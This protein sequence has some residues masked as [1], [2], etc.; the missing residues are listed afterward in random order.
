MKGKN[1]FFR[2]FLLVFLFVFFSV[3]FSGIFA[4]SYQEVELGGTIRIG[5]FIYEDDYTPSTAD[6]TITVFIQV[7]L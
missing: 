1:N 7:E 3:P 6:C 4:L 5:E 2:I